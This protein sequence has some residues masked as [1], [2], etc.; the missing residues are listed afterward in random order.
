MSEIL[1][2]IPI[3]IGGDTV[4]NVDIRIIT[5]TNKNIEELIR[6][7]IFREDLYYRI[8]VLRL[9]IPEL[10]MRTGLVI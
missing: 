5:A 3:R 6:Q 9:N 2:F 8:N 10:K 7:N 1:P 4:V